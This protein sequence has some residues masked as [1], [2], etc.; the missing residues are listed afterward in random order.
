VPTSQA[1][2]EAGFEDIQV[3]RFRIIP[4]GGGHEVSRDPGR[5]TETG[6]SRGAR[7]ATYLNGRGER[8]QPDP[9]DLNVPFRLECVLTGR[10]RWLENAS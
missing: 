3:G 1:T 4:D 10:K 7:K 6:V 5:K 9:G 2:R 8:S